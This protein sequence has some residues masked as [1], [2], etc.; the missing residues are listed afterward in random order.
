MK[1]RIKKVFNIYVVSGL[2]AL[3]VIFYLISFVMLQID[4][5][6]GSS[7]KMKKEQIA[8]EKK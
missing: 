5:S 6:S 1:D 2:I 8:Q 7:L 4:I 3:F